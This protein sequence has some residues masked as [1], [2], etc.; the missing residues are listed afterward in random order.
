MTTELQEL[1]EEHR[2][3]R[4]RTDALAGKRVSGQVSL[5]EA[6]S[7]EELE[8]L[9]KKL[10]LK[11][12]K[13]RKFLAGRFKPAAGATDRATGKE[14]NQEKTAMTQHERFDRLFAEKAAR[15]AAGDSAKK[16]EKK[17]LNELAAKMGITTKA[18]RKV[19][20][21]GRSALAAGEVVQ[22]KTEEKRAANGLASRLGIQSEEGQRIFREGRRALGGA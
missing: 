6:E 15:E 22:G 19:F 20:R 7:A 18:G 2:Q 16:E 3:I 1:K 9:G 8:K 10:G 4:A 21:E 5:R 14:S 17:R 12:K 13:L 11:G